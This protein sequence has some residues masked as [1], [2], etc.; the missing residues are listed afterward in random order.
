MPGGSDT[1]VVNVGNK[2]QAIAC[3]AECYKRDIITLEQ[4]LLLLADILEP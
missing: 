3:I 1:Y 4:F 2:F